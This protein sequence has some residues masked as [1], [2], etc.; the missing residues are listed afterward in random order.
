MS[1]IGH[2]LRRLLS[3]PEAAAR[4]SAEDDERASIYDD[5]HHGQLLGEE[6]ANRHSARTILSGLFARY[7]PG[8]VLDVGC[9]IGTWLATARELGVA[10]VFGIEGQWLDPKLARIPAELIAVRDLEKG[11]DLGR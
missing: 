8:S 11:F 3:G 7:R 10:D 9:G 5:L 4:T 6:D 2:L 1:I